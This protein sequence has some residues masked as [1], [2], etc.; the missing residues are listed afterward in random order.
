MGLG[1]Q[2][3]GGPCEDR[4]LSC[5]MSGQR[6]PALYSGGLWVTTYEHLTRSKLPSLDFSFVIFMLVAIPLTVEIMHH[7]LS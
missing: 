7:L 3:P 6:V 5:M 4:H 1:G 2:G